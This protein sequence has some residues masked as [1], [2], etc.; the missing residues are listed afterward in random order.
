MRVTFVLKDCPR[1]RPRRQTASSAILTGMSD[2]WVLQSSVAFGDVDREN[3]ITLQ[4]VFKHL[5]EAAIAHANQFDAGTNAMVARGETWALK[6]MAVAI[7]RYPRYGEPWRIETWSSGIS[8]FRGY[9]E[10]RV[11]SGA[12]EPIVSGSSVW[13]Y[14]NWRT[15]T[16]VRRATPGG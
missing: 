13:A 4:G 7:E 14:A 9:R 16:V 10:F 5:Q 12:D 1:A 15:R 8:G 2:T 6:R 11:Y 3:V